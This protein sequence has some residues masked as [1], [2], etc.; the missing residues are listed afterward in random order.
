M[1]KDDDNHLQ[2]W[3]EENKDSVLAQ[4]S[5]KDPMERVMLSIQNAMDLEK[6]KYPDWDDNKDALKVKID[7]GNGNLTINVQRIDKKTNKPK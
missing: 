1:S 3:L 6:S 7:Q 5:E 4:M 2:K